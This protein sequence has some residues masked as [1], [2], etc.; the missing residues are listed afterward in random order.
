MK[1][2]CAMLVIVAL[3][4]SSLCAAEPPADAKAESAR[5][6]SAIVNDDYAAF[7]SHGDAAFGA[8]EK[9]KF[10]SVVMQLSPR[11]KA[12]YEVSYLGE[13]KQRG[14]Q[15]TLWKLSFK[16]AGD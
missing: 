14:Y 1:S 15:V 7:V 6:I 12:G 4:L 9:E 3:S 16:D 11:F 2:F 13:M 5:L 10:E 8:L